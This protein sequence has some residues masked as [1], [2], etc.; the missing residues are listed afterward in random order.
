MPMDPR[1]NSPAGLSAKKAVLV[2]GGGRGIGRAIALAL[3]PMGLPV[4]VNYRTAAASAEE[5]CEAVRALGGQAEAV[6]AD[7]S[8]R[9]EVKRLVA[10]IRSRGYWVHTLINNAGLIRDNFCATLSIADWDAV[11]DTNLSGTF[12][13]IR[14]TVTGMTSRRRGQIINIASVS[15]LRGQP[16]QAN[17]G[18]AKAGVMALTRTLAREVGRFNIRVNAV[19]PGFIET[20]ML[21]DM[22]QHP[23]ARDLLEEARTKYIPL[24]RFGQAEEVGQV[25]AFLC[26]PAASYITGHVLVVDGGLTA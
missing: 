5:T 26:S 2:T 25:V 9:D 16:G 22:R 19:A 20:D 21:A 24:G 13:C 7:V 18:A 10:E 17:Y 8:D 15:G 4:I 12:H 14:E 23:A 6:Q 3:A 1:P 11:I